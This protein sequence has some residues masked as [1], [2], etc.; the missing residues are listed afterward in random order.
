MGKMEVKGMDILSWIVMVMM[1][2]ILTGNQAVCHPHYFQ[3]CFSMQSS[4]D[5]LFQELYFDDP[6][7]FV[8][9][10]PAPIDKQ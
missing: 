9:S 10:R 2:I 6:A 7:A 1:Y 4:S 8:R 3:R 5:K